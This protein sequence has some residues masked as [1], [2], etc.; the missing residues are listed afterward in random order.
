MSAPPQIDIT[1]EISL[2]VAYLSGYDSRQLIF[3][4]KTFC[5]SIGL[6]LLGLQPIVHF[7][8]LA[9][10]LKRGTKPINKGHHIKL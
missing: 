9:R 10:Q 1:F 2:Y 3:I 5:P 7:H 6:I 8:A 4:S